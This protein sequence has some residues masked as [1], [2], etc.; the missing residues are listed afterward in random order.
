MALVGVDR[1]LI[2]LIKPA[3]KQIV[4]PLKYYRFMYE[5]PYVPSQDGQNK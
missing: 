5:A 1:Q 4:G 2:K 3:I